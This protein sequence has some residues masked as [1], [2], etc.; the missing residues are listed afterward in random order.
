MK[1]SLKCMQAV[2]GVEELPVN[3]DDLIAKIGAQIGAIEEITYL[4][5][6]YEA[7]V[8]VKIIDCKPLEG[9]DHLHVCLL[10]DKKT[11]K[12]VK[13]QDDNLIQVVCG[14]PNV[15][16]G[17]TVVWLP[18]GSV[19]PSSVGKDPFILSERPIMGIVSN[20][21]IA[22]GKELA[23]N[24]DHSGI[25]VLN[26]DVE[27]GSYL[28][29]YLNLDD[30]V[31]DI[32]NK[33]FTHR[34]DLFGQLGVAREISGIYGQ[35]FSSPSWYTP[36]VSLDSRGDFELK[37]DNRLK[38]KGCPRFMAVAIGNIKVAP[39]PLWLQSYL[40]RTGIRPINNIVDITN[41]VMM[42][43]GQPMHA[44]DLSKITQAKK[45]N[46]TIRHPKANEEL[47]LLDLSL[48]KLNKGDIVI[49][50]DD[51]AIGLGGIMGGKN[52]EVD[53]NTTAILLECANFD[54]YT[55][56]RSSFVNGIFSEA[57]TRFTK[58]QSPRQCPAV[59]SYAVHLIKEIC[60]DSVLISKVADEGAPLDDLQDVSVSLD[61]LSKY[62]GLELPE[63]EIIKLLTNVEI[64]AKVESGLLS[65]TPPFWRTD[66]AAAE[67]I[68]EEVARLRG[69]DTLPIELP[70]RKVTPANVPALLELKNRIRHILAAGGANELLTYS[71]IDEQ[72]MNQSGQDIGRSFKIA[73]ALSPD[74]R[75]YRTGLVPGLLRKVHANHKAGFA[76]LALFEIGKTH[77]NDQTD[78]EGMP[79]ESE[80]FAMIVSAEAKVAKDFY[81]GPAYYQARYYLDYL[82]RSIN[83]DP[84]D[85]IFNNLVAESK[86]GEL[87]KLYQK[88]RSAI[89]SIGSHQLGV[90]GE[91]S[92]AIQRSLKLPE[93]CAGLEIDLDELL[94]LVNHA[95]ASYKQLSRYPKVVQDLTI[96]V[97]QDKTYQEI[98]QELTDKL[99]NNLAVD[100]NANFSLIDIYQAEGSEIKNWTFRLEVDSYERTLTDAEVNRLVSEL[101]K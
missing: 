12:Q 51:R 72:L 97:D 42:V 78:S 35:K 10:D 23:I 52:S 27:I 6:I 88:G 86:W 58:G 24:D 7:A 76:R 67:D 50:T 39:S 1:V 43:T 15:A 87:T 69:F 13:R 19:V 48:V 93:F 81:Q 56:R 29:D 36:E 83:I 2:A 91:F 73:N 21:M 44:Y 18:P 62:L 11:V 77:F 9:S 84:I 22:S 26:D 65:V 70:S 101:S 59:L 17:L 34:P 63:P 20:G 80:R 68:I 16:A 74:L 4:K 79:Y 38:D 89:V 95:G 28:V 3:N 98:R 92:A 100:M 37:V 54:M 60:P 14:A 40:S 33:M 82:L 41:Y 99:N 5:P 49:A 30:T 71:F 57:V 31:I 96:S 45:V 75:Y 61:L 8:I 55:I 90:I 64:K 47:S 66:I 25:V 85:L 32:E 53:Q 94:S 46:I